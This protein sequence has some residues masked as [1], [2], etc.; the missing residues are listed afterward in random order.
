MRKVE[1][2]SNGNIKVSVPIKLRQNNSRRELIVVDGVCQ[3]ESTL[4]VQIAR[5]HY[6]QKLIDEGVFKDAKELAKAL[7]T[8]RSYIA[9]IIKLTRLSPRV[10]HAIITGVRVVDLTMDKTR[11]GIPDL[12]SEQERMFFKDS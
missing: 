10:T 3:H 1:T 12:W 8:D 5:G 7:G 4:A 2:L 6:W 11:R 9:R